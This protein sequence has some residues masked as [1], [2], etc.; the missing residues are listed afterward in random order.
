MKPSRKRT[1][2]VPAASAVAFSVPAPAGKLG[3]AMQSEITQISGLNRLRGLRL[4]TTG[5]QQQ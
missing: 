5:M 4:K 3:K 2:P 1:A